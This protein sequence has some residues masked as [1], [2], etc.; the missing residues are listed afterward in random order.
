MAARQ[1]PDLRRSTTTAS[2]RRACTSASTPGARSSRRATRDAAVG[3]GSLGELVGDRGRRGA[4]RARGRLDRRRRRRARCS[5]PS[6]ACCTPTATR[7]SS[8]EQIEAALREFLG[9]ERVVWLGQGLV[10]DRDTDGHV[11]L[12]AAFT[13]P[14]AVLLQSAPRGQRQPR[15]MRRER[16]ARCA[17]A[18]LEVD[19]AAVPAVRS[20]SAARRS[21]L[22]LPE[23]LRLQRR[24]DRARRADAEPTTRRWRSDRAP[25]SPTARSSASRRAT[26]AYGG[27]GP[28]CITQQ[29]PACELITRAMTASGRRLAGAD[30]GRARGRR[31]GSA[32][33]QERWHPDPDEHRAALA[34]GVAL[35]A[36]RGRDARLPA[37]ADAVAVLRDHAGR[38]GGRRRRARGRSPAARRARSRA[39]LA[40]E[41]GAHVHASLYE[42]ADG[43]RRPRLQHRDRAS[44]PT[45]SS[46]PARASSTSRSPPATTRTSYFRPGPADG[47]DDPFPVV[48]L[49]EARLGFPTCWDQW[50]PE[51][52]RAYSLA[53]AEVLVYPTAIGSEPDHPGLRHPAAV[54]AGDRRQRDRQRHVHGRDQPDRR[55]SRR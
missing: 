26:L 29:V 47:G 21:R 19:R 11:D 9:V 15:A 20:R 35:A 4:V 55:P 54:A 8:R 13:A 24:G 28:H 6:S 12:I 38:A 37:G 46:S 36:A 16:A 22:S 3:G 41:T 45:A 43:D 23:P 25:R 7:R 17:R 32:L 10:E 42:R 31:C 52:A 49:G 2:A 50:F 5:R 30:R 27:G 53:G 1:R 40:A 33:V 51:L 14:G 18:G 44:R 48:A 34:E 39:E